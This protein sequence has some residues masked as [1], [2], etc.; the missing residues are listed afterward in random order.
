MASE[1]RSGMLSG[2]AAGFS[3]GGPIGAG[4][5][6]VIGMFSGRSAE[7]RRKREERRILVANTK[8]AYGIGE[9]YVTTARK[10]RE[11]VATS[12][13]QQI[14]S[15]R[16]RFAAGGAKTEGA[17]WDQIIGGIARTR[18]ESLE[19]LDIEQAAYEKTTA[20]EFIKMDYE[21]MKEGRGTLGTSFYT[22]QQQSMLKS[23]P[24]TSTRGEKG[25]REPVEDWGQFGVYATYKE[26]I[27]PSF[28]EYETSRFGNA[29][30]KSAFESMMTERISE[31]NVI[32][33][34]DTELNRYTRSQRNMLASRDSG[35][36]RR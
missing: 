35:R 33:E 12:Y 10:N 31:A 6:A 32:F 13:T 36:G 26:S 25:S 30:D 22:D 21:S 7:R 16:A 1:T 23:A 3:I 18:V 15:A 34:R 11:Q 27:T 8:Q 9:Q 29:D 2:A 17:S 19:G 5:G 14:S 4:I 24:S 20:Y 28:E